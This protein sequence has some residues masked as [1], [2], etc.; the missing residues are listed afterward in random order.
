MRVVAFRSLFVAQIR[1]LDFCYLRRQRTGATNR[2]A[3]QTKR[4][5]LGVFC[6]HKHDFKI[7]CGS[8]WVSVNRFAF[9]TKGEILGRFVVTSMMLK[10]FVVVIAFQPPPVRP[11][12]AQ[13]K[14]V[15]PSFQFVVR[16]AFQ[17]PNTVKHHQTLK[18]RLPDSISLKVKESRPFVQTLSHNFRDERCRLPLCL[19]EGCC[20]AGKNLLAITKSVLRWAVMWNVGKV[21]LGVIVQIFLLVVLW[22]PQPKKTYLF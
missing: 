17:P 19:V 10:L 6:D 12:L 11:I 8:D 16:I 3:F 21:R 14:R 20:R 2:F 9:Q 7:I 5:G 4:D 22:V 18:P 15:A 1:N 13:S